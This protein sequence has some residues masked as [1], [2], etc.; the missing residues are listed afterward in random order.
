MNVVVELV[1]VGGW[2]SGSYTCEGQ[3]HFKDIWTNGFLNVSHHKYI[4][5][6]GHNMGKP[7]IIDNS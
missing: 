5:N 6:T 7:A 2:T 1:W 3:G 4:E